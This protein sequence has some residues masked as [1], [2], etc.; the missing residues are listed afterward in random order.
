MRPQHA[1]QLRSVAHNSRVTD[2]NPDPPQ[3]HSAAEE[4]FRT[5]LATQ[6]YPKQ[7]CWLMPGD[8]VV[9]TNRHYWV[10]HK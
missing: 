5:F 7:F 4:K 8:V 3:T 1:K 2:S 10:V 9:D 6:N